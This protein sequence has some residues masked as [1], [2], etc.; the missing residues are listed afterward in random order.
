MDC[1]CTAKITKGMKPEDAHIHV[2]NGAAYFGECF[3]AKKK[4]LIISYSFGKS[5]QKKTTYSNI[6][7]HDIGVDQE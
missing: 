5:I 6:K 1:F 3:L 4:L 7:I 2:R